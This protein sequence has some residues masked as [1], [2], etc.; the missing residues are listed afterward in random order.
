MPRN[1]SGNYNLPSGNPVVTQTLIT[2]TWANVTMADL[3]LAIT[4]SLSRDGQT[5]P[6]ANLPMGGY[7][8]TGAGAPESR[9][10]YATLGFVQDG[11]ANRLAGL[12]GTNTLTGTLPGS[13]TSYAV[14]MT[15][16]MIPAN[17][18]T[19]AATLNIGGLGAQPILTSSGS[20]LGPKILKAGKPYVLTYDGAAFRIT[21]GVSGI[22]AQS[23]VSGWDRPSGGT[24]PPITIVDTST[25]AIPAGTG[26][27]IAPGARD[28]TGAFEVS[29]A[30]QDVSMVYLASS[31][32]TYIA[33]DVSGN[34]VQL[35]GAFQSSYVRDYIIL[36]MVTHIGGSVTSAKTTPT[37]YGDA[38]YAAYDVA[39]VLRNTILTGGRLS[40]NATGPLSI[41]IESGTLFNVGSDP[42]EPNSPNVD[43]FAARTA[44]SFFPITGASTSE[45]STSN[46]PVTMYDPG[47]AG[48]VTAIP[49]ATTAAI[50]RL[51]QLSD[52][53]LLLYGQNTYADLDTAKSSIQIDTSASN[54]PAKLADAT[55]LGYIIAQKDCVD[56]AD[57]L[58]AVVV[59][60]GSASFSVGGGGAASDAP[61]D[62]YMYGRKDGNWDKAVVLPA[63][64]AGTARSIPFLTGASLRWSIGADS[65]SEGGTEAGSNFVLNAYD[66]TGALIGPALTIKRDGLGVLFGGKLDLQTNSLTANNTKLFSVDTPDDVL[67]MR[68]YDDDYTLLNIMAP[69]QT[70]WG[71]ARESTIALVR[72]DSNQYFMDIY[73]MDYGSVDA[74]NFL[75]YG[76]PKMGIRMQKRGT[77]VYTPF[78]LEYSDGT[79]ILPALQ[80]APGASSGSTNDTSVN[81]VKTPTIA[82]NLALHVGNYTTYVPSKT[83]TGASGTWGINITGNAATATTAT[84]A[85][86]VAT[87]A[88]ARTING[89]SFNGSANIVTSYWGTS[90]TFTIGATSK[91]VDG[92]SSVSWSLAEMGAAATSHTHTTANISDLASYT[93]FDARYFTE[94]EADARF[95]AKVH[96]HAWSDITSGK[97]TTLA[98][99]GVTDGVKNGGGVAN[100][101]SLTQAAYDAL[102]TKDANT[103][104]VIVG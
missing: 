8:H 100:I 98:G 67:T 2:S 74:G 97:P 79:N 65:T 95:A 55:L 27:I 33:I 96:T 94:T 81:V 21:A 83:G 39:A 11:T 88:T 41:D 75:D 7:R 37:I 73:N 84:T 46:V 19:G 32:S 17:D 14:G 68:R 49:G 16:Q 3:A 23:A 71:K 62:G 60:A 69:P 77:G 29:W 85:S 76:D 42:N 13:P 24:Y 6:T 26:R 28:E 72:G 31:W 61:S 40:P 87:L 50:H 92:G 91:S 34:V 25:V 35:S 66:N 12:A 63:G 30:A 104:Y 43:E 64:P 51:Y 103:L 36:G 53:L 20:P 54:I 89:T 9:T 59:S 102:G 93:G 15:V 101:V 56:L 38:S 86:S 70:S 10:D 45:A 48:S 57:P 80:I 78:S 90:R 4:Q 58:T 22:F 5:V 47:G 82:G 1:G 18:N 52:Q 99:Y 44:P